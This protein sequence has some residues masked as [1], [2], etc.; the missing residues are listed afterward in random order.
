MRETPTQPNWL[1]GSYLCLLLAACS[2]NNNKDTTRNLGAGDAGRD[3][4]DEP[5]ASTDEPDAAD[6]SDTSV[7]EPILD[8]SDTHDAADV[9]DAAQTLDAGSDA[10]AEMDATA[11][12]DGASDAGAADGA[13]DAQ[14][15]GGRYVIYATFNG[16][17]VRIDPDTAQLTPIGALRNEED[18]GQTFSEV[19]MTWTGEGDTAWLV[20]SYFQTPTLATANLC[21]AAVRLGPR[22]MRPASPN[23]VV[24]GLALHP[25]GNFYVAS[26]NP[27][28]VTSPISSN[29]GTVDASTGFITDRGVSVTALQGDIDGLFV[30]DGVLYGVDVTTN[31][32]RL[33]LF[34][35][36]LE[37]GKDTQVVAPYYGATNTVPLRV[38]YDA[39]RGK[40][41]AW[42]PSDRNLLTFDLSTGA[43]TPIGPT[44]ASNAPYGDVVRGFFVAPAP[45][46]P[47]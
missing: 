40:A 27:A 17:L 28:T 3:A 6:E 39:S 23:L 11:P 41:F 38:A 7:D 13:V 32:G 9:L 35:L 24:E 36:D 25:N 44:H 33:G 22:F 21:T 16:T 4:N 14:T 2:G 15:D 26:G 43:V 20:T 30:R 12:Q 47:L 34:T 37:T 19:V 10:S 8:A 45:N 5:D 46:C 29:L 1:L 31:N 42:R 18:A